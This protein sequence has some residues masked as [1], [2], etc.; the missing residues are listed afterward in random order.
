MPER[1]NPRLTRKERRH[2]Q[3]QAATAE[4]Y[5]PSHLG[6]NLKIGGIS[7]SIAILIAVG[8]L[9]HPADDISN[10]P[11]FIN[12]PENV[13]IDKSAAY[14][15]FSASPTEIQVNHSEYDGEYIKSLIGVLSN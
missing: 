7:L 5:H 3:R 6:R 4:K 1:P 11:Q 15:R 2:L 10:S 14:Y 13:L 9:S 8:V 12:S